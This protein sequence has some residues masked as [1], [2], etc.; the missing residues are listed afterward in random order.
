MARLAP[1][2]LVLSLGACGGGGDSSGGSFLAF[3]PAPPVSSTG[4]TIGGT[5]SGL[6]GTVVLRNNGQ[7]DL[8]VSANGEFVFAGAVTL[9]NPYAVTIAAQP[10]GQT[11]SVSAGQGTAN[12]AVNDVRVVCAAQTH[13]V[14]GT[15]SGLTGTLV[16]RNNGGDELNVTANGAFTFAQALPHGAAY[17]VSVRTQ[18][19]GQLCTL[20]GASGIASAPVASITA[21][22]AADPGSVPPAI[23]TTPSLSYAPKAFLFS[24]AAVSGATY[25]RL[26]EDPAHSGSFSVLADN[27]AATTYALQN[28]ALAAPPAAYRY[29]LQACN[30]RGCSPWSL[31]VLPDAA[32]AIGY[33]KRP[34]GA[35]VRGFA[36]GLS[37]VA[38]SRN[39]SLMA[40]SQRDADAVHL[41]S[42]ESGSWTWVQTLVT[43]GS[44]PSS[45]SLSDEGTLLAGSI[46]GSVPGGQV[47]VYR[48]GPSGWTHEQTWLSPAP[49]NLGFFGD[50]VS[51]SS[52]GTVAAIGEY[53]VGPGKFHVFRKTSGTWALE[54]S[55]DA[56]NGQG[57]SLFG[58]SAT[59]SGDGSTIAVGAQSESVG[60]I[61][62][63]GAAYVY[64]R[65]A[66]A[67]ALSS[68]LAPPGSA[69]AA[70][71]GTSL[72]LSYDGSVLAVGARNEDEAGAVRAG[73]LYVYRRGSIGSG[74]AMEQRLVAPQ[75]ALNT[76]FGGYGVALTRDGTMLAVGAIGDQATSAGVG[77]DMTPGSVAVGAVFLYDKSSSSGWQRR[78]AMVKAT[79]PDAND[80]F[81]YALAM[82]GDG[83]TLAVSAPNE[84]GSATGIDGD[85]SDN[86]APFSGAVYLY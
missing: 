40:I 47:E 10:E 82:S 31:P 76:A 5:I 66:G 60:G 62:D 53:F 13:P 84:A 56:P 16:L 45:L 63:A 11:C 6:S 26:G 19:L 38:I 39:G 14:G 50:G 4:A 32:K 41:F 70:H 80:L 22:C 7:D 33:V 15:V 71:F 28:L 20:A 17:D 73:A 85:A 49:Q 77:G 34:D 55:I 36:G 57:G 78:P 83:R 79:N 67:W 29:A 48:R 18:P 51:I 3:P 46:Q 37:A 81:G 9:G 2:L 35:A 12:A 58:G 72:A 74:H 24:W 54:E 65:D 68:R 21:S 23:P 52:D 86:S 64:V 69:G 59:I 44:A 1:F 8:R 27:L 42:N 25:Y 43:P 61:S 30:D 75:P